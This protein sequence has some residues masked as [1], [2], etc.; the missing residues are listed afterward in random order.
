MPW[1]N[2]ALRSAAVLSAARRR[3]RAGTRAPRHAAQDS[4]SAL[5]AGDWPLRRRRPAASRNCHALKSKFPDIVDDGTHHPRA[6]KRQPAGR[7]RCGE[8]RRSHHAGT[9]ARR[10]AARSACAG[11]AATTGSWS[12]RRPP[13]LPKPG[14]HVTPSDAARMPK[15]VAVV[16]LGLRSRTRR[17]PLSSRR[18]R[19]RAAGRRLP[20]HARA[21]RRRARRRSTPCRITSSSTGATSTATRSLG[22]TARRRPER[23][24]HGGRRFV[25]VRFQGAARSTPRRSRDGTRRDRSSIARNFLEASGENVMFGG[26]DP[27]IPDA[28][29]VRHRGGAEPH[30]QA[31]AV[32][33]GRSVLRGN[34]VER[35]EPVRAQ[36]CAAR[37]H[38]RQP[39]SSTTGRTRR[40]VSPSSSPSATRTAARPG[41]SSRTSRSRTTSIR[42]VSAGINVLGRDDNHPSQQTRRIA[43]RNNVLLDVGGDWGNGRLFQLLNGTSGIVTIDHNTALQTGERVV[44][45]RQRAAHEASS[46]RT[47]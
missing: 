14:R 41:R 10:T 33:E 9:A 36:E 18:S 19:D 29:A 45:R 28:R 3:W 22:G 1:M 5:R 26:A 37:A 46:S 13:D 21:T 42:H 24:P 17:T 44:R 4:S 7:A 25:P 47:T 20:Q 40:T 23:E 2:S 43:I 30:R 6:G 27:R 34:R 12:C 11:R 38:R 8:R 15:L 35:Q 16:R 32:E 39:A 31:A